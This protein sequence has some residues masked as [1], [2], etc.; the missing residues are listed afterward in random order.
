MRAMYS[1]VSVSILLTVGMSLHNSCSANAIFHNSDDG[2]EVNTSIWHENGFQPSINYLGRDSSG[3]RYD[4]GFRF[5]VED[6]SQG[7]EIVYARLRFASRGGDVTSAIK[8]LI[9]GVLQESPTT[10]SQDERPSQ[11]NPKTISKI[12]WEIYEPWCEG[13]HLNPLFYSSPDV[14]PIINEILALPDWG[15]GPEGKTLALTIVDNG[16]NPNETNRIFYEDLWSVCDTIST[17]VQLE[18]YPDVY[19][20][21]LGREF[22]GRP[23]DTSVTVNLYSLTAT[24]TY[25]EYGTSPGLYSESSAEYLNHPAEQSLEIVLA[26]L[27]AN[28]QYYYRL[29]FRRSGEGDYQFGEEHTF[30]T[31]PPYGS[32]FMFAVNADEHL[33]EMYKLPYQTRDMQLYRQTLENIAGFD[34]DFLIS[35]GD[36]AHIEFYMGRNAANLQEAKEHYLLQRDYLDDIAHSIPFYLTIGN[37]EGEQGWYYDF[38]TPGD[39]ENSLAVMATRA[40]K[41][42]IPNPY[43]DEFYRGNSDV[44]PE[45]GL[46]EDYYSWEWGDVLFVVLDPFWYTTSKPHHCGPEPGS[47][48]CWDWS[49]GKDQ[50][51]WLYETLDQSSAK[52]K[53]VFIHHLTSS[54]VSPLGY[55]DDYGRGGIEAA[56]YEVDGGASYE[57]GGEDDTGADVFEIKRPGW[58]Y[59]PTHDLLVENEVDIVFH[60]H[61]HL[62]VKQDLDGIVYQECPQPGDADYSWGWRWESNYKYGVFRRNAGCIKVGVYQTC[63]KV[64]YVQSFLPGEGDNGGIAYSYMIPDTL[65]TLVSPDTL[66]FGEVVV[67]TEATDTFFISNDGTDT[68]EVTELWWDH[69][70]FEVEDNTPFLVAPGQSRPVAVTFE[71][72]QIRY[73]ETLAEIFT[74]AGDDHLVLMG[75]GAPLTAVQ[76]LR[77]DPLKP[78]LFLEWEPIPG[79]THYRIYRHTD[80]FF[81]PSPGDSLAMTTACAFIDS[82]ACGNPTENYYYLI[83]AANELIISLPSN[84]AGEFDRTMTNEARTARCWTADTPSAASRTTAPSKSRDRR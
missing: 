69:P 1:A 44:I 56:K 13:N 25:I 61:D 38:N 60:G 5:S 79:A 30:R 81:L 11:K 63:I 39:N 6:L 20:A 15:S 47:G 16:S 23:T 27:V 45:Y 14:S 28:T 50:Y 17:P 32:P 3:E 51:D 31:Q 74:D 26:D 24:D 19:D 55:D 36:F 42:I 75:Q 22:L 54:A 8:L 70:D 34:P 72:Q 83:C 49:L 33:Q 29:A 62:F 9:E 59:G 71:P 18:I 10:F 46:R 2:T 43:P 73:L 68:L 78:H 80:P 58:A 76:N 64:D 57:W 67:G 53:F 65:S 35:L 7:E 52:W 37:H 21:F 40:R 66:D 84:R 82:T 77:A 48:D 12:E 41:E 4:G